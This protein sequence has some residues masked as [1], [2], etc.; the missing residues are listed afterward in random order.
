MGET[1]YSKLRLDVLEK[2]IHS[3]G[4]ECKMNKTEMVRMLKLYDDGKYESKIKETQHIKD[5]IGLIIGIDIRNKDHLHQI[6]KL[7]EKKESKNL[8]RFCDERIW[9][10]SKQKLI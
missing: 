3:R 8:N 4:I 9:Y 5:G 2:L 6:S 10:W 7:I 1:N